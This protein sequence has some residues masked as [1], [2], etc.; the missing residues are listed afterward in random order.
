MVNQLNRELMEVR[1]LIEHYNN[2][3]K[4]DEGIKDG[5][6]EN[7]DG[8]PLLSD[9]DISRIKG[10]ISGLVELKDGL[11]CECGEIVEVK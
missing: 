8:R 4:I 9:G 6:V 5:S 11:L 2:I 7:V 10:K 3:L 1:T